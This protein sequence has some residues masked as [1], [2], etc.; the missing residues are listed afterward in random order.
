M[1]DESTLERLVRRY[2]QN[3]TLFQ[4]HWR[5]YPYFHK[6]IA[7]CML[8]IG[9]FVVV[10][11]YALLPA[12]QMVVYLLLAP[13]GEELVKLSLFIVVLVSFVEY[14]TTGDLKSE[15]LCMDS[16]LFFFLL[17]YV[18]TIG[19]VLYPNNPLSGIDLLWLSVK[20]FAGHFALTVCGGLLFGFVYHRGMPRRTQ[21]LVMAAALGVS[22]A[23]HSL[24]NQ[25]GLQVYLGESLLRLGVSQET[26]LLILFALSLVFFTSFTLYKGKQYP[27]QR[28]QG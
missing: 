18:I 3:F 22:V 24:V 12:N 13:L 2:K 1:R 28:P 16:L 10:S 26:F 7:L 19:E 9:M 27:T 23:L 5:E 14:R 17:V 21:L 25:I 20:K 4:S 8:C 11:E 6:T 15:W